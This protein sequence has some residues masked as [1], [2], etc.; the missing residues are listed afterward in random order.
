[1]I[2]ICKLLLCSFLNR[3]YILLYLFLVLTIIS[4]TPSSAERIGSS[5]VLSQ[6]P[7]EQ[8]N[9]DSTGSN[10]GGGGSETGSVFRGIG[11]WPDEGSV[12][13]SEV[14]WKHNMNR[15]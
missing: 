10:Q 14:T 12:N 7:L 4:T 5:S 1:M 6:F 13:G 3:F 2:Q 11:L 9:D 8:E 15:S